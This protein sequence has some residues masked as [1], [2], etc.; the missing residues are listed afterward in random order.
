MT[1]NPLE[2]SPLP[3]TAKGP[4][5]TQ[6]YLPGSGGEQIYYVHHRAHGSP[7]AAVLLLGPI[8]LERAHSY[9]VWVR[10]ARHLAHAN[11]DVLRFD[12]RGVGESTGEFSDMTFDAWAD[13]AGRALAKLEELSRGVPIFLHGLRG[14][15]IFATHA[16]REGRGDG[17]LLWEPP[18][19]ASTM[20]SDTLRHKIAADY[21]Q[22]TG[23]PRKT[24]DD[25]IAEL[26]RGAL[27]EVEG[28]PWSKALWHSAERYPL[29][30]PQ[31]NEARSHLIVHL[32]GRPRERFLVPNK[33]AS[34]RIPK[35]A[36]WAES[37]WLRPDLSELFKLSTS[38]LEQT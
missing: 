36:F 34:L 24:R 16:F 20:L 14:G 11:I 3:D 4:L 7:R 37:K 26:D 15:A 27:V 28:Y 23:S 33:S 29:L 17:L 22:N 32:D 18:S 1:L 8:A 9:P 21:M 6:D 13:D 25:Y 5:E 38:F 19:S 35:P 12:Y 30:L 2:T 31:N 10:W